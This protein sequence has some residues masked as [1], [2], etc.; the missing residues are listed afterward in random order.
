MMRDIFIGPVRFW[1]I[2]VVV[3]GALWMAGRAQLHVTSFAGFLA[4][5]AGLSAVSVLA[6]LFTARKGERITREPIDGAE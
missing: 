2:W 6:V 5:L 1:A 3:L 4:L